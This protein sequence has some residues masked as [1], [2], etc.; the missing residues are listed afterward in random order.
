MTT[1]TKPVIAVDFTMTQAEA[2]ACEIIQRAPY[3]DNDLEY[4][5]KV[6]IFLTLY[7]KSKSIPNASERAETLF[8]ETFAMGNYT[9]LEAE[10][11]DAKKTV[12][13]MFAR[14]GFVCEKV[15]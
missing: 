11:P 10:L 14:A 9:D 4:R 6:G 3:R 12:E 2:D 13:A 8:L 7:G 5:S 1:E 15:R